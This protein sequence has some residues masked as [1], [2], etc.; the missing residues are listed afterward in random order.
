MKA[1]E[2]HQPG[3]TQRNIVRHAVALSAAA[4]AVACLPQIQAA[5]SATLRIGDPAPRLQTS[6]WI[7]GERVGEFARDKVYMVE[8]WATWCGLCRVSNPHLNALHET[9]DSY[10]AGT[11]PK[12]Y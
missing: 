11:V 2:P 3:A 9:L 5:E 12:P 7:Q 6:K 4:L 8:F 1:R 10:K